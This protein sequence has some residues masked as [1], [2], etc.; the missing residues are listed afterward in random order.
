MMR[1]SKGMTNTFSNCGTSF[2]QDEEGLQMCS[3]SPQRPMTIR[4]LSTYEYC[5]ESYENDFQFTEK[6]LIHFYHL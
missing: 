2:L 3:L 6:I 5:P 1:H 4:V